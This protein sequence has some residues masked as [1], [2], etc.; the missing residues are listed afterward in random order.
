MP[1]VFSLSLLL[2]SSAFFKF[3]ST[4]QVTR[5]VSNYENEKHEDRLNGHR[6]RPIAVVRLATGDIESNGSSDDRLFVAVSRA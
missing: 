1:C 6:F 4:S 3:L 5:T 2:A